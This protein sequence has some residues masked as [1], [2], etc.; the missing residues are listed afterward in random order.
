ML[1]PEA[2][3]LLGHPRLR[4]GAD[5][6]H[7]DHG[8]DADHDAQHGEGAPE[9]VDPERPHRDA[10]AGQERHGAPPRPARPRGAWLV[11]AVG[12]SPGI[13]LRLVP[14]DAPVT[15]AQDP[16]GITGH[17]G[18]VGDDDDRDAAAVQVLEQGH[19]LHARARVE[20]AG[21]LVGQDE[22]RLVDEGARDRDALLLAA[23]ELRGVMV[24]AIRQADRR[25]L[26]LRPLP[27]IARRRLAVE[28]RQLHVLQRRRPRQ[29]IEGLEDE[30]DLLV[31]DAGQ[32]VRPPW[33]RRRRR[34]AGTGR[35][36]AC[37]GSPGG[38]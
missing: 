36:S 28:Q 18:L 22:N 33:R 17:V 13:G 32:L 31:A 24:L 21:G 8:P 1:E 38:S 19:D 5:R 26:G 7:R 37:P 14:R 35:R 27:P 3:D 2:L 10:R 12:A 6:D 4:A 11:A 23:R 16:P 30:A 25:Q 34:P 9:L 29:E 20:G 15:E